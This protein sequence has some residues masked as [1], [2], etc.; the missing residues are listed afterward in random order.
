[1][2]DRKLRL[3]LAVT[4]ALLVAFSIRARASGWTHDPT[5]G[6]PVVVAPRGQCMEGVQPDSHGGVD[7][8]YCEPCS[9]YSLPPPS[10][11]ALQF[12]AVHLLKRGDVDPAWPPASRTLPMLTSYDCTTMSDGAGG[13]FLG[14]PDATNFATSGYDLSAHHL[15]ADG[16]LDPAWPASGRVF[17]AAPGAQGSLRLCGDRQGGFIAAWNDRRDSVTNGF[18]IYAMRVR[19][20]GTLDPAWPVNGR[21]VYA[22]PANQ[23][24]NAIVSDGAGGAIVAWQDSRNNATTSIDIYA[25][26]VLANG[27]IDP[28]WP[29][30]GLAV[31]VASGAQQ[32]PFAASDSAGGAYVSWHDGNLI[33]RVAHVL[34]N[35]TLDPAWPA[36]GLN[37]DSSAD[38]LFSIQL[39]EDGRGGLLTLCTS[40]VFATGGNNDLLVRH[41]LANGTFDPQWPAGGTRIVGPFGGFTEFQGQIRSDGIVSDGGGGIIV[42]YYAP[43]DDSSLNYEYRFLRVRSDGQVDPN[44]NPAGRAWSAAPSNPFEISMVQNGDGTV[45]LGWSDLRDSASTYIDVYAQRITNDGRLGLAPPAIHAIHDVPNDQGGRATVYWYASAYDTLQAD[46]LSEYDVWRQLDDP[47]A[48]RARSRGAHPVAAGEHARL[49]DVRAEHDGAKDVFW[50]FVGGAPARGD[51]NYALTVD[52]RGDS[53]TAGPAFETYEVD[54]HLLASTLNF[55]GTSDPDSGYSIDNIPPAAPAPFDAVYNSGTGSQLTWGNNVE[56]DLAGYRLYRGATATFTPSNGS[57]IFDGVAT[58]FHDAGPPAWFKVSAY[59]RHGN[60]GPYSTVLSGTVTA[61]ETPAL[62]HELGLL[63]ASPNPAAGA[64]S[65][66]LELPRAAIVQLAVFDP[67]GRRVRQLLSGTQL[68]GDHAV[69]WDGRSDSG[70]EAAAGLYFI[71]LEAEG[72]SFERR[73]ALIR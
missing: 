30:G 51:I 62:P 13:M 20:N 15:R 22:G 31:S 37:L 68:A 38:F 72:R 60:E 9:L 44:W 61:V 69:R 53:S 21:A 55:I 50:E 49:G 71:R 6:L 73:V 5:R 66:R 67:Q 29:A 34:A 17:C 42:G 35:G 2:S 41:V 58:S 56:P 40:V 48:A 43:L 24:A 23:T 32:T 47:A 19:A 3:R 27:T 26:H 46:P 64:T 52:T 36:G 12:H 14:W 8:V 28:A 33:D 63:P 70:G 39:L 4:F 18:D 25:Q 65:V 11:P 16:S 7:L 10:L 54:A 45:T 59:D 1:M 57:R